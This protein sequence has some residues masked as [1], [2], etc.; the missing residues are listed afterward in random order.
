M[1]N[2]NASEKDEYS[3]IAIES[4]GLIANNI[5]SGTKLFD[6]LKDKKEE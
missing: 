5:A 1:L 4:W 2:I 3:L 6:F